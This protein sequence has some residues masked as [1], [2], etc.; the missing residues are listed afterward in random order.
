MHRTVAALSL[1]VLSA[2]AGTAGSSGTPDAARPMASAPQTGTFHVTRGTDT[3]ARE[4]FTRT[5]ARLDADM[6]VVA[7]GARIAYAMDLAPDASVTRVEMR[8]YAPGAD[9]SAAQRL[10]ATVRGDSVIAEMTPRGAPAR[11]DRVASAPGVVPYINPSPSNMEQIIRRARAIGGDRVQVPIMGADN[12][13]LTQIG[14]R[15][16]GAD[17]AII[18]LGPVV[19]RM[20]TDRAGMLLGGV[21]PSQNLVITRTN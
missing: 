9:T 7:A 12:G 6:R 16:A 3:I 14:V 18:S 17:S 11:T 13:R 4:T 15:F 21:V 8:A 1:A 19:L 5:A 10:V 2:C 20:R